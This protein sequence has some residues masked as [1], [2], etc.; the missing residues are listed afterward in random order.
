MDWGSLGASWPQAEASKFL[1]IRPH[2]WHIQ[3][4]GT[5]PDVLLLHGAGGATH[6][7]AGLW[8]FLTVQYR[9]T[10]LDL[11][12]HGFTKL[13]ALQRSGL[14]MMAEDLSTAVDHLGLSP[15]II[16][17]HSAGGALALRLAELRD[18]ISGI[19]GLN[20]ALDN[21]KG[22]AG[23]L[24]PMMAKAL[25]MNPFTATAVAASA[26]RSSIRSLIQ[27]TGSRLS[28]AQLDAYF[29]CI[30]DRS[31]VDGTLRMMAQ[32]KLDGLR[33][34]MAALTLPVLLITGAGDKTVPPGTSAEATTHL[35]N[36]QHVSLPNLGHL[37]HEE[38]P[39]K[40]F[41]TLDPFL[42]EV[43]ATTPPN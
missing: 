19:V 14:D 26:T 42:T 24:F 12:G 25:A 3:Q 9:V 4:A 39:E 15:Q 31:H 1:R 13:G 18:D 30:S 43:G 21:F 27:G 10:A 22:M 11:P 7:W 2:Q 5:G 36:A 29:A 32:W 41:A 17:G 38:A 37:A 28:A 33:Q 35:V 34:R 16:I 40:V 6:S 8:P 20:A 23:T